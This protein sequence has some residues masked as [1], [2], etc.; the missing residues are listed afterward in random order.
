MGGVHGTSPC[1]TQ[2]PRL[3][4]HKKSVEEAQDHVSVQPGQKDVT[5]LNGTA[6]PK[7]SRTVA[8][9]KR[10]QTVAKKTKSSDATILVPEDNTSI[11]SLYLAFQI[12]LM[13]SL[14]KAQFLITMLQSLS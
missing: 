12:A 9:I 13:S 11:T 14:P 8:P 5:P 6:A 2:G 1:Y 3:D 7:R 4:T 10:L